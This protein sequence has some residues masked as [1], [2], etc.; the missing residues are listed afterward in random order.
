MP[1]PITLFFAIC[2][3]ILVF[4]F[5]FQNKK[6]SKFAQIYLVSGIILILMVVIFWIA[7]LLQE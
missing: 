2:G 5:Y 6:Q 7:I 4:L 1:I 3:I